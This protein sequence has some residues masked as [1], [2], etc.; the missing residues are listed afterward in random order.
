MLA[1]WGGGCPRSMLKE[2]LGLVF[3]GMQGRASLTC[4][5]M[6]P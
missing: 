3:S 2:A 1:G 6:E 5:S 4:M